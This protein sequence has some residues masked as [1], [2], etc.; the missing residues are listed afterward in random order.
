VIT[1]D[2]V[3][4][5][6]EL[7]RRDGDDSDDVVV[8]RAVLGEFVELPRVGADAVWLLGDGLSVA[9]VEARIAAEQDV[10]L[11]V[12]ELAEA[13]VEL[14]FVAAVDDEPLPDPADERPGSHLPWLRPGHVRWLFG[15]TATVVWFAVVA[16]GL[17]K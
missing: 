16:A 1:Q 17:I 13:L 15:R 12:A 14:G 6:H 8:G 11:D 5:L 4:R 9:E 2:S 7:A 10:E 3:L